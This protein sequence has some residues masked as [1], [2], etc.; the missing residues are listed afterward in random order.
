MYKCTGGKS[1]YS[2][3]MQFDVKR[4][5]NHESERAVS[6]SDKSLY[7]VRIGSSKHVERIPLREL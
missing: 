4:T 2:A 1:N 7:D 5:K 3:H 6:P